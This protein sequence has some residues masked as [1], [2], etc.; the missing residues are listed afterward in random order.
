MPAISARAMPVPVRLVHGLLVLL[1][2][3][4]QGLSKRVLPR[5]LRIRAG[6]WYPF[7]TGTLTSTPAETLDLQPGELVEIKS[8]EEIL[9]TVDTGGRNRGLSFDGEMIP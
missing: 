2:N 1:F 4:Y 7:V 8:R 9:A 6:N 3:K 5:R